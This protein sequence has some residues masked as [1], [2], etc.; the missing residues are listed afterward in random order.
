MLLLGYLA[1]S[2]AVVMSG[3]GGSSSDGTTTTT[4][5]PTPTPTSSVTQATL[6][7]AHFIAA[8]LA[9]SITEESC[10][11]SGGTTTTCYKIVTVGTPADHDVGAFCPRNISDGSV[12]GMWIE[13]GETYDLTGE[14]IRN[15]ATF[16]GDSN[17][18]LYDTGTGD[19]F[20]TDTQEAFEGAARPDV[21]EEYQNHC[22]EGKMEYVNGGVSQTFLIPKEPVALASGT[23]SIGSSVGIGLD[24][25]TIDAPAPVAAI[26]AAYTIAAFDDC[27]GHINPHTGYHYHA[28]MGCTSNVASSDGHSE[29]FAYA[30]DGYGIYAQLASDGTE[31][32]DLDNCRGH[33][34]DTR[35][36]HYHAASPGENMHIGCFYGEQGSVS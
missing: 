26:K 31:P 36:Y 21:A 3:C 11:L 2:A 33:S 10:T 14:F 23:G 12:A 25:I 17:W 27:G 15:L 4:V 22:V 28:A 7:P 5:T 18:Q 8:G 34:D 6:D 19:I 32:T 1:L 30:L 20:V 13:S 29:L 16:Y 24:G 35:G 9:S